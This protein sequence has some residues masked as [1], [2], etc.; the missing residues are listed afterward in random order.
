M[1][2]S[3]QKRTSHR[4]PPASPPTNVVGETEVADGKETG[5]YL[6]CRGCQP[7]I[8]DALTV[9]QLM[10]FPITDDHARQEQVWEALD[11]NNPLGP[12]AAR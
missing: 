4:W 5:N 10:A 11:W 6:P 8:D 3:I 12:F 9:E 7:G 2:E 1:C